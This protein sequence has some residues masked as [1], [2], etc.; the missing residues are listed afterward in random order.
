MATKMKGICKGIKYISHLFVVKEREIEIGFPTDVKHVAHIGLD[1]SD[2]S[3][4]SWMNEFKAGS[5]SGLS[6]VGS[7]IR[8]SKAGSM[9]SASSSRDPTWTSQDFDQSIGRQKA[10]DMINNFPPTSLPNGPKKTK[11]KKVK[12]S[13]ASSKKSTSSPKSTSSRFSRASRKS[14]LG[15]ETDNGLEN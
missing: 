1:G 15:K 9:M 5:E 10:P 12:S 14:A 6:S 7:S 13:S 11:R 3:A 2:G 4:P 8:G